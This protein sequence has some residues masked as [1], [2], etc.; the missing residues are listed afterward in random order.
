MKITSFQLDCQGRNKT[1]A[2]N[3]F[4]MADFQNSYLSTQMTKNVLSHQTRKSIPTC[5]WVLG[6]SLLSLSPNVFLQFSSHC[7]MER[8]CMI[9]RQDRMKKEKKNIQI[10][11][12]NTRTFEYIHLHLCVYMYCNKIWS[13]MRFNKSVVL[14][15]LKVACSRVQYSI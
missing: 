6:R 1:S 10:R 8:I 15:K 14:S 7:K 4:F 3:Q 12:R 5:A 2:L 11:D 13:G 9:E